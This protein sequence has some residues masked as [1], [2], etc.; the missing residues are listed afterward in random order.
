VI[1]LPIQMLTVLISQ[2]KRLYE[3]FQAVLL[4]IERQKEVFWFSLDY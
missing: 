3:G 1:I 4:T 2:L